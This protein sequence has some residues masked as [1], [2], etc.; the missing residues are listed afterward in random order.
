M[1]SSNKKK[2]LKNTVAVDI[3][4]SCG[5][6]KLSNLFFP[7]L[8]TKAS[9]KP[10]P[11]PY[12]SSSYEPNSLSISPD[13]TTTFDTTP[14]TE[15]A[16]KSSSTSRVGESVAVVKD[17]HDPYLDFRH[18]MLQMILEKEIYSK[19]EL[20]ELLDCFLSLNSPY[21]HEIILRAF[22]EIWNGVFF[23]LAT[24]QNFSAVSSRVR[25]KSRDF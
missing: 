8:K 24:S 1:S 10:D 4:C 21:H 15:Y 17:S 25:R 19:E 12:S 9:P 7:K 2:L 3:G 22:S 11:Y 16:S 23:S 13:T 18:S 5:K 20:K 6:P 14:E